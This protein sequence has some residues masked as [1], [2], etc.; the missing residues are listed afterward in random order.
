MTLIKVSATSRTSA[1]AG[2]I[3]GVVREHH[4]AEVQA[5]GAGAVNQAMKALILATGYLRLDG[6]HVSCVPEFTDVTIDAKERTAIKLVVEPGHMPNAS[7][8]ADVT[9][10]VKVRTAIKLD[11]EPEGSFNTAEVS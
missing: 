6:I 7:D 2:A 11:V 10:D 4:R 8:A 3:A 9:T 5:I 1:V